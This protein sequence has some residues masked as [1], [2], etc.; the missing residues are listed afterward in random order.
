VLTNPQILG[1]EL[2]QQPDGNGYATN[3]IKS[4]N[5][6]NNSIQFCCRYFYEPIVILHIMRDTTTFF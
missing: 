3:G 2:E 5:G 1:Q 6:Q 4:K